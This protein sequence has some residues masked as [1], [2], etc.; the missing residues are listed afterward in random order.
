MIIVWHLEPLFDWNISEQ[1]VCFLIVCVFHLF[2]VSDIEFVEGFVK[3][4]F[5]GS[6]WNTTAPAEK[7]DRVWWIWCATCYND[8][9]NGSGSWWRWCFTIW[10]GYESVCQFFNLTIESIHGT[11]ERNPNVLRHTR[12]TDICKPNPCLRS[13]WKVVSGQINHCT[14]LIL[15]HCA[16][17]NKG[18]RTLYNRHVYFFLCAL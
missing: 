14:A 12:Y 4:G 1:S 2:Q 10:Q 16:G 11:L 9:D 18:A 6:S 15:P 5:V 17:H 3:S 13:M 7:K 8:N